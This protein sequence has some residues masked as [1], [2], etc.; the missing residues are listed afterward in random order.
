MRRITIT[1][2]STTTININNII[3]IIIITTK[4]RPA[5]TAVHAI[6]VVAAP[7]FQRPCDA[8]ALGLAPLALPPLPVAFTQ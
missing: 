3:I 4:F 8:A 6:F 1:S 5:L 2:G 7:Y